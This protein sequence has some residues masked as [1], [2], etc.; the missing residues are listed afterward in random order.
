M[1]TQTVDLAPLEIRA[2]VS[3]INEDKRT[4]EATWS[5]GAPVERY[6]WV[7]GGRY[8]EILSMQPGHVRLDRLNAGASLLDSHSSYSLRSILGAIEPKTARLENGQGI[9]TVR[10]S[11]RP[12]VEP[13]WQDVRDEIIRFLSVGY[14]VY[15]FNEV[16][17]KDNK[18]PTRT[19]VDWEPFEVSL[20]AMP[21]DVGSQV[22]ADQAARTL[23]NR[24]V[25]V[26]SSTDAD[27]IRR[28]RLARAR[29]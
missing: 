17:G 1:K 18:L 19:A 3:S 7:S 5:T 26:S 2:A 14:R 8:L 29:A 23:T 12:D 22:R 16:A 15:K 6:D 13:Y 24:C 9:A 4:V 21:A 20:V 25:I 28:Y 11:R 27:R 10:F